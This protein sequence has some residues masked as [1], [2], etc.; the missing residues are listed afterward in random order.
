[1]LNTYVNIVANICSQYNISYI[2]MREVYLKNI[3]VFKGTF[4]GLAFTRNFI[5]ARYFVTMDGEHP[6]WTGEFALV[7]DIQYNLHILYPSFLS[8]SMWL[9]TGAS[10]DANQ[11]AQTIYNWFYANCSSAL[12]L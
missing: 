8:I 2:N 11:F 12:L 3:P 5:K 6:N 1:M 7:H 10:R 4:P 9:N